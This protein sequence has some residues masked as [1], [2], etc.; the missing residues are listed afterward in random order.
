MN[1]AALFFVLISSFLV[2]V[3]IGK[4]SAKQKHRDYIECLV[5]S[6]DKNKCEEILK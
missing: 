4:I 2:G 6:L 1:Y 5:K 3:S